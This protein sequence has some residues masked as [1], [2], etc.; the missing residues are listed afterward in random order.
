MA[1][2]AKA[3]WTYQVP[4]AGAPSTGLEEYV[5]QTA[6]GT[7][8]GKVVTL[9]RREGDVYVAVERGTPPLTHDLRA[10]PW[11]D[12]ERVDHSALTVRLKV[13]D[14]AVEGGLE[15]DPDKRTEGDEAEA[16][17]VTELPREL[18][19]DSAPGETTEPSD[20]PRYLATF[21]LGALGVF[22]ALVLAVAATATEFTWEFALFAIPLVLFVLAGASGYRTFRNPYGPGR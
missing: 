8:V 9:V 20:R 5:V 6:S 4:P 3:E 14:A 21:A 7:T 19:P 13:D 18:T 1:H 11:R 12:V 2:V 15:L 17:R 10:I 22:S 16:V